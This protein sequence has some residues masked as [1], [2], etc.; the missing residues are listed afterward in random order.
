MKNRLT[1]T[2]RFL[3]I[4]ITFFSA[5]LTAEKTFDKKGSFSL[6]NGFIDTRAQEWNYSN[7]DFFRFAE[8]NT[9]RCGDYQPAYFWYDYCN[10]KWPNWNNWSKISRDFWSYELLEK[11]YRLDVIFTDG[12]IDTAKVIDKDNDRV[13]ALVLVRRDDKGNIFEISEQYNTKFITR[14]EFDY[15]NRGNVTGVTNYI[16]VDCKLLPLKQEDYTYNSRNLRNRIVLY[17][18]VVDSVNPAHWE[19]TNRILFSYDS[20]GRVIEE[21]DSCKT[22]KVSGYGANSNIKEILEYEIKS[23]SEEVMIDHKVFDYDSLNQIRTIFTVYPQSSV[24]DSAKEAYS[25]NAEANICEYA[26]LTKNKSSQNW[27]PVYKLVIEYESGNPSKELLYWYQ[28]NAWELL[29]EYYFKFNTITEI[30]EYDKSGPAPRNT[31]AVFSKKNAIQVSV[32][33]RLSHN[34]ILEIFD[35]SGSKIAGVLPQFNGT[36]TTYNWNYRDSKKISSGTYLLKVNN[37]NIGLKHVL[38]K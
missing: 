11:I 10:Q 21:Y 16:R 37:T 35:L 12:F 28:S 3:V 24:K 26:C 38:V 9:P 1:H 19:E 5:S 30:N 6:L 18:W 17:N 4:I 13:M 8:I 25:Y 29:R 31:I 33:G 32:T 14:Y 27:E 22:R 15:N 2:A 23:D 34:N 20:A 7:W 36:T